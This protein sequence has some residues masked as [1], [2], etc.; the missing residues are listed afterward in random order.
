M[1]QKNKE[2]PHTSVFALVFCLEME[3]KDLLRKGSVNMLIQWFP[4]DK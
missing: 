2:T 4:S 3:A 1:G